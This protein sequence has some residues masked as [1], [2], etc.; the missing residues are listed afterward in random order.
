MRRAEDILGLPIRAGRHGVMVTITPEQA[1]ALLEHQPTQRPVDD[2]HVQMLTKEIIGGRFRMTHQGVAF[3]ERGLLFDGQ[4]RLWACFLAGMS[5]TVWVFFN[6]PRE[7]F[8]IVDTRSKARTNGQL[9]LVKGQFS[10]L[11][12]A[13]TASAAGRFLDIYDRG[14]NPTQPYSEILFTSQELDAVLSEHPGLPAMVEQFRDRSA[15]R[16]LRLPSSSTIALFVMF[17]EASP[18]KAAIFQRQVLTGENLK[19]GDPAMTL[20]NS[21]ASGN[22]TQRGRPTDITYRIA[23]AWNHFC[24]GRPVFKLYGSDS[25]NGTKMRVGGRDVFPEI[26]GYI[27]PSQR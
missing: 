19:E 12:F 10:S 2:R 17:A 27:R 18:A 25:A 8:A 14:L 22:P 9:A 3:D 20:R 23:R 4:H 11:T 1:K 16:R 21:A 15:A 24:A 7:N 6:E 26:A 13:N 5:I